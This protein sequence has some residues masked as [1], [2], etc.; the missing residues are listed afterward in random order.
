MYIYVYNYRP[1]LYLQ[2]PYRA[3]HFLLYFIFRKIKRY[4]YKNNKEYTKVKYNNKY[5]NR[6]KKYTINYYLGPW[7]YQKKLGLYTEY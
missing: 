7:D 4:R 1:I 6:W 2:C 3:F 5:N